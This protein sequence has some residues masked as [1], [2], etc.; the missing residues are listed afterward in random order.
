MLSAY[1][2]IIGIA[3]S[4]LVTLILMKL[5]PLGSILV[6][7]DRGREFAVGSEVN[8]GK[9]TGVGIYFV[10]VFLLAAF[11]CT[12]HQIALGIIFAFI[13]AE[14]ITG[15]LDDRSKNAWNPYVKGALDFILAAGGAFFTYRYVGSTVNIGIIKEYTHEIHPAVYIVLAVILYIVSI[16]ATNAT[17]GVDG[18]SG[19][20]AIISVLTGLCASAIIGTVN[21]NIIIISVC[22]VAAVSA[23]L[24]FN[25]YPSKVLMGDAGSRAIGFFLAFYF[26]LVKLPFLYLIACLPF[27]CDGGISILKITV[28][29]LTKKK[30][31]PFRN[32]LTPYHDHLKKNKGMDVPMVNKTITTFA[33]ALN[34]AYLLIIL[35]IYR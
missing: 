25:K 7:K 22:F 15:I 30:I 35:L 8:K 2:L 26:M 4:F 29:R 20:L 13:F 3:V 32:I 9:P 1:K 28:G 6:G 21:I 33:F 18:L 17:D 24:L 27:I 19:S 5:L 34:A 16:N 12:G 14:M 23:Y 31:L 11:F 10:P